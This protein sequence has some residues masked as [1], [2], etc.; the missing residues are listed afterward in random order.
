MIF[1]FFSKKKAAVGLDLGT[2]FIKVVQ[3]EGSGKNYTL[4]NHGIE[5]LLPEA[6]VEGEIMDREV[7]IDA[8]NTLFEKCEIK[9]KDVI[10]AVSGRSVM[11]KRI[12]VDRM[13][14]GELR[15][16]IRWEAEQHIPFDI[17]DVYLDVMILDES[18]GEDQMS[19]LLVAAKKDMINMRI[20]L[21]RDAGLNPICVDVDAYAL[22]NAYEI[23]YDLDDEEMIALLNIGA[24]MTNINIIRNQI[25]YF[26]KDIPT[27]GNTFVES[28]QREHHL[29]YEEASDI[30]KGEE[31]EG[32]GE[33]AL[34]QTVENVAEKL[35]QDIDRSMSYVRASSSSAEGV[36]KIVLSGGNARLRGLAEFL[37][38]RHNVRLE[39]MYPFKK[40][41]LNDMM[42]EDE[43]GV[44]GPML[45]VGVGLAARQTAK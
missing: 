37:E 19:V 1:G 6:I 30:L 14:E 16:N 39:I 33:D 29:S 15:Q 3:L 7:V 4:L 24:Y 2:Q 10:I 17:D 40:I 5:L 32:I 35:S 22:Q 9:T 34:V 13:K 12:S 20:E 44:L 41:G 18:S 31:L 38:N 8:I 26:Q 11:C 45:A 27:A 43:A 36:T 42:A 25:T 21:M 23:N 28:I